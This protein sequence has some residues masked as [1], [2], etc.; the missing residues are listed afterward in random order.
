[1]DIT[2]EDLRVSARTTVE[3]LYASF[4]ELWT[5]PPY[6]N[7]I[8]DL[9]VTRSRLIDQINRSD[10]SDDI[11]KLLSMSDPI[12]RYSMMLKSE[13]RYDPDALQTA[14]S[15]LRA[16]RESR[17]SSRLDIDYA[18]Q[19]AAARQIMEE[20]RDVLAKLAQ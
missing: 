8:E 9:D 4:R 19:M 6:Q 20:D 7:R 13:P 12:L 18:E 11:L 10:K 16:I 5:K 1:M 15:N 3:H 2:L 14:I 17:N